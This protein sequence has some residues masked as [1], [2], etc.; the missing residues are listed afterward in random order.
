MPSFLFAGEKKSRGSRPT[1][2]LAQST[3]S[4]EFEV[5]QYITPE[6]SLF[7]NTDWRQ[8]V[9]QAGTETYLMKTE[10]CEGARDEDVTFSCV[11]VSEDQDTPNAYQFEQSY[12]KREFNFFDLDV[13]SFPTS[14]DSGGL[15]SLGFKQECVFCNDKMFQGMPDGSMLVRTS[16]EY[17]DGARGRNNLLRRHEWNQ[18]SSD[19]MKRLC[20]GSTYPFS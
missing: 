17:E 5:G 11:K 19:D 8:E 20:G 4:G 6:T 9:L 15:I 18:V 12:T 2:G 16:M 13:F 14:F 3:D 1:I 7:C 10:Q